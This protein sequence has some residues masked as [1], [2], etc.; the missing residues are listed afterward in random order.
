MSDVKCPYC[1]AEQE[2]NHDDGYGYEEDQKHEQECI[3][4]EKYFVYTTTISFSYETKKAACLNGSDH[5][6]RNTMT[7]PIRYTKM[8]CED[9]GHERKCTDEELSLLSAGKGGE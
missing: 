7:Y 9:C 4:C 1:E 6:Y 5:K 8:R 3:N 2:I